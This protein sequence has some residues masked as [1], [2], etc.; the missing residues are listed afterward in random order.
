MKKIFLALLL[1]F[2]LCFSV[3]AADKTLTFE[4]E[5]LAEDLPENGGSLTHWI[6][7]S[8]PDGNLPLDQ[9]NAEGQVD[10]TSQSAT[11][12][13]D[14]TITVPDGVET[15]M[16]FRMKAYGTTTEGAVESDFSEPAIPA[17]ITIDFKPPAAPVATAA[18][19]NQTKI[20][21]LSW[22]Q[23]PADTDVT[24][25]RVYKSATAGG[26]YE[27]LGN[28]TSPFAYTVAP[29]DSGKWLYFVV[30]AHDDDGNFSPNSNEVAVKLVMGVPFNLRVNVSAQ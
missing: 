21:T 28:Q 11:Y 16:W 5:Q 20:V 18:Y 8:S 15:E 13:G 17:P 14:F 27:D 30:V 12:T 9:W 23:D 25:H 24:V 22:T 10:Y 2:V 6:L 26:P 29:A 1:S 19:N 3:Q 4:W 7:Y